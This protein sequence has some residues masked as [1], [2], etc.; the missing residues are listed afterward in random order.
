MPDPYSIAKHTRNAVRADGTCMIVA[1]NYKLEENINSPLG[2]IGYTGSI[3]I[4][5][6]TALGQRTSDSS[7][8]NTSNNAE[9]LPLGAMPGIS[10]IEKIMKEGGF[11]KF[12]CTF[13]NG[14]IWCLRQGLR[15]MMSLVLFTLNHLLV[16]QLAR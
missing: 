8:A 7:I 9:V 11:S 14:F 2:R 3:F 12:R 10:K 5:I 13:N 6:P 1:S 16:L 15:I 4:C